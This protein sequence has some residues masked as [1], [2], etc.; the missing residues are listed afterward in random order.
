MPINNKSISAINIR[1]Y[2]C[3]AEGMFCDKDI[4]LTHKNNPYGV[5]IHLK[6]LK[7]N[8]KTQNYP[9]FYDYRD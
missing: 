4:K 5:E 7:C 9:I 1:T 6:I 3:T 2:E 8:N